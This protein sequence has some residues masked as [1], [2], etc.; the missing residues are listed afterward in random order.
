MSNKKTFFEPIIHNNPITIQIL[1]ICSALAVTTQLKPS[2]VMGIAVTVIIALSNLVVSLIRSF[3]PKNIRI[4][5]EMTII[6][7][8]VILVDQILRAYLFDVSKQLSVFVG[9]IITNCIVLGRLEGFALTNKPIPSILDG[10]G[11]GIGYSLILVAVGATRE[12]FGAGTL[13]GFQVIPQSL[14]N[15][16]Y[17]NN[18]LMVL[19]PGAF[20]LLGLIVW[21]Q[22]AVTGHYEEE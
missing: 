1:G 14:Y 2:L 4:I 9:L 10:F 22:R 15:V 13:L 21:L 7:T 5:V 18:G 16:G 3:I 20:F 6:A 11:N 19:A 17:V 12:I 8:M